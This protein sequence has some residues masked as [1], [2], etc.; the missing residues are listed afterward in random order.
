MWI[1]TLLIPSCTFDQFKATLK[2]NKHINLTL[3]DNVLLPSDFAEHI[4]HVG[5][6]HDM[7]SIILSG[8]IAGGKDVKKG[9]HA[10][11]FTAVN[12]IFIDHYRERDYD[13]TKPRIAVHKNNRKIHQYTVYWCNLRVAQSKGLQFYQTRSNAIIIYNTLL[14]MCIEKVVVRTSGE[15]FYSKTYLSPTVP[16]R[17]VLKPNLHH[18]RQDTA[19]SDARTSFDHSSTKK[20]AT[21]ERTMKLVAVKL[22]SGSKDCPIR[23]SKSKITPARKQSKR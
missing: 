3:Q 11:F 4:Y 13:V 19:S 8:L 9:R 21:V 6:S 5:S 1:H 22:A 17:V 14:A 15:E 16:R 20:I 2:E 12:P 23:P 7:H 10:V 18:G